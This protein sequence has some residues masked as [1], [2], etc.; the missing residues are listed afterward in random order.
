MKIYKITE[1]SEYL[2]VSINTLKTLANNGKIKSF[3]TTGEHRRFRQEDLDAYM[4]VEK[5]KQE[6]L[7]VIYVRCST[8]KKEEWLL[9]KLEEDG[10]KNIATKHGTVYATVFESVTV[11]DAEEFLTWV[12][13]NDRFDCLE[14]RVAKNEVLHIMGDSGDSGRPNS[15]PPGVNYVAI[16]KVIIRKA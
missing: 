4:G 10:A 5:E 14:K 7:T 6:K 3:K 2:G 15:P 11:A 1:A 16:R 12:K 8:A 9:A 13:E